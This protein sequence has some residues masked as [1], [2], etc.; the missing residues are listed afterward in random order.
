MK[1]CDPSSRCVIVA[2]GR[3]WATHVHLLT[4]FNAFVQ[5]CVARLGHH[6]DSATGHE[7]AD[8]ASGLTEQKP[9]TE[10][11]KRVRLLL[12]RLEAIDTYV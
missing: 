9:E 5:D 2:G 10:S 4:G 11:E 3:D 6:V 8:V 12:A 1:L 7:I